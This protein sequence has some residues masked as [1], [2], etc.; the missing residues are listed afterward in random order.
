MK[1]YKKSTKTDQTVKNWQKKPGKQENVQKTG[2]KQENR[3]CRNPVTG[4]DFSG[5]KKCL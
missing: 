4:W 5:L 1:F 2:K 3:L